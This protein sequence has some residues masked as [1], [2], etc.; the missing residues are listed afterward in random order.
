[1]DAYLNEPPLPVS[2][3]EAAGGSMKYWYAQEASRPSVALMA[4][5]FISAP[6]T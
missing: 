2:V 1:M 5:D 6:G 3:I 4:Q